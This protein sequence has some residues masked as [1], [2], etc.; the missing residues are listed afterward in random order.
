MERRALILSAV[1][2]LATPVWPA[3]AQPAKPRRIGLLLLSP[4]PPLTEP[5]VAAP[6]RPASSWS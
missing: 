1:G 3:L 2:A 6:A 5:F 4:F